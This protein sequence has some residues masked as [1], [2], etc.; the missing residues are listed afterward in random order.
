MN[1][2]VRGPYFS[3]GVPAFRV[4]L[5]VAVTSSD[6]TV[7]VKFPE[8]DG[9]VSYWL[10]VI[11]PKTQDDKFYWLPD[12]G[13]QVVV[14]MDEND[15]G[16]AV[17]GAIYS[18]ADVTPSGMTP[19]KIHVLFKDGT[20]VEYDR[21]V[22]RL[23]VSLCA[24]GSSVVTTQAGSEIELD[25]TGNVSIMAANNGKVMFSQAGTQASDSVAVVSRLVTAFNAHVHADP[26][27]AT[28]STPTRQ[29]SAATIES[30]MISVS[31]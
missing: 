15:E 28:T 2:F 30:T 23:A 1:D 11:V 29:W 12:V 9:V 6:A 19:D 18:A 25:A 5:V 13:E 24:G 27:G 17:I 3:Q 26:Q 21:S 22:H 10:P 8:R 31:G 20:S 16:G 14:L 7:R 4:G